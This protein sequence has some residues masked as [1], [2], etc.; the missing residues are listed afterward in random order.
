LKDRRRSRS[1]PSLWPEL[2]PPSF[3]DLSEK[4]HKEEVYSSDW[5]QTNLPWGLPGL[6]YL[7][8]YGMAGET[9]LMEKNKTFLERENGNPFLT[10]GKYLVLSVMF[11]D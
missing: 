7:L 1:S 9:I 11:L 6:E 10:P 4:T 5:W 3:E 2:P 8:Y